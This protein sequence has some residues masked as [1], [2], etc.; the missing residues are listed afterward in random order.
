MK[1]AEARLIQNAGGIKKA[2]IVPAEKENGW[3]VVLEVL[4]NLQVVP[5]IEKERGGTRIFKSLDAAAEAVRAIGL[6]E[7]QVRF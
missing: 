6:K 3:T 7:A 2:R 4:E 1:I 5:Q